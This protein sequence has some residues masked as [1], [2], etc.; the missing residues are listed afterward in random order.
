LYE[1]AKCFG[2]CALIQVDT[3]E[4]WLEFWPRHRHPESVNRNLVLVPL[5][6][7]IAGGLAFALNWL[8]AIPGRRK[9]QA[10][11]TEQARVL[12]PART[13]GANNIWLAPVCLVLAEVAG[14]LITMSQGFPYPLLAAIFG[15]LL[16]TFPFNREILP[17]FTFWSWLRLVGV[18]IA[19]RGGLFLIFAV[20]A[21]L[22]PEQ[23]G[24]RMAV[25]SG[26]VLFFVLAWN[27]GLCLGTLRGLGLL[28]M[29]DER[30]R[31]IVGVTSQ[32]MGV[33]EPRAWMMDVPLAQAF[34]LPTTGELLFTSRL[35]EIS[36]DE[37]VSAI[38]AHELAHL[39]ESKVVRVGRLVSTL[40]LYPLIFFRTAGDSSMWGVGVMFGLVLAL[41]IFA[42]RLS[43]RM[44]IRADKIASANQG[45]DG[46]Y[47]RALEKLYCDSL[48]PA[49]ASTNLQMHPHLYD[50]M[51]AAG[52]Q[53]E[54][55]RP[56]KP[57]KMALS[58]LLLWGAYIVLMILTASRF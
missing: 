50:R 6:F 12:W 27:F 16:G 48:I 28:R 5:N 38:C 29:A 26:S 11:W 13:A 54:Y 18:S 40:T 1:F 34:A 56:A 8:S 9:A 41:F 19:L 15:A 52:V 51:M 45:E 31:R 22:M 35:L 58:T 14:G 36:S 46:T 57:R 24:L 49:V 44:E 47:A 32:R 39:A 55:P 23:A 43:R 20:G 17:R 42:R 25:V 53:P 7:V 33:R 21:A 30:L 37:E 2:S 4:I 3:L 10:H